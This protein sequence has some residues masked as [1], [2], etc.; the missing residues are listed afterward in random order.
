MKT[1]QWKT[2][3]QATLHCL[4][5]CTV[6]EVLGLFLGVYFQLPAIATISLA[7]ALAFFIGFSWAIW[8][9]VNQQGL[10]IMNAMKVIWLGELL[11][12]GT[13]ELV[14][15]AVDYTMGGMQ[16]SGIDQPVFW[17][18]M[19]LALPSGFLAA[20]PVNYWL[21]KRAIKSPCCH[22]KT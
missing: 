14:M 22:K 18:A 19:G 21:L 15:N 17:I 12:M 10:S 8:P 6:G 13:M 1:T 20:L 7:T 4:I 9:L 11:S 16:A 3:V 2:A 5:G